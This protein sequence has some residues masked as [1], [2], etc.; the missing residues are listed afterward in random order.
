MGL[1]HVGAWQGLEYRRST[2]RLLLFEPQAEAFARLV[3]NFSGRENVE[4]VNVALGSKE[5][6]AAMHTASPSH[7]SSLLPARQSRSDIVFDGTETV[8]VTTLDKAMD[9]REGFD[10]LRIDTQGYELEVLRGAAKTLA[11]IKRVECEIHDPN[12]YSGAGS[13][14]AVDEYLASFGFARTSFDTEG[15]DNMGDA[16]Y[17]RPA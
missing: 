10:E 7:S 13:L 6:T 1:I 4:L 3:D 16:T 8:T 14:E 5:G 2:R 15:S 11:K 17:E 9:G 12:T